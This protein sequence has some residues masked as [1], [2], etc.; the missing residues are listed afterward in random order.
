MQSEEY[1]YRG[2]IH[3]RVMGRWFRIENRRI[4]DHDQ[5]RNDL[6]SRADNSAIFADDPKEAPECSPAP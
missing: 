4:V 1:V 2:G 3:Q 5:Y 6:E